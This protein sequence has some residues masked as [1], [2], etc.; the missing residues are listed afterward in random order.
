MVLFYSSIPDTFIVKGRD[1]IV[2]KKEGLWI[3]AENDGSNLNTEVI[4][5]KF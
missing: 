1:A 2:Y 3:L 5:I 4:N